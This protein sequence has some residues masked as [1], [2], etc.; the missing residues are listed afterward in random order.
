VSAAE[1]ELLR[2]ALEV[3]VRRI[4]G[5]HGITVRALWEKYDEANRHRPNWW[6]AANKTTPFVDEYSTRD[7]A[8][9]RVADWTSWAA[10]RVAMKVPPK[11]EHTYSLATVN[12]ELGNVKAMFNWGVTNGHLQYNPLAGA[13]RMKVQDRDTAPEE[14]EIGRALSACQDERQRVMVLAA[15]DVGLRNTEIRNLRHDWIDFE[16]KSL[17]LPGWACKNRR[18][19]TVPCTQRFLDA[20]RAVPRHI[21]LPQ[22][23]W[24]ERSNGPYC[25]FQLDTWWKGIRE[26]AGLMAAPGEREVR[27]HDLRAACA[28]NALD[29]GVGLVTI[30]RRI[31][32]HSTLATT[33]KY[34]RR[35]RGETGNLEQAIEAMEAGI[36]RDLEKRKGPKRANDDLDGNVL[37]EQKPRGSG[38]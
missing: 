30:S 13:K 31:L 32:R 20:V 22:V 12:V 21:R 35:R 25:S 29:R 15:A 10:K 18:G 4:S 36:K 11:L 6:A 28:T 27:L 9:L 8:A 26:R 34:L 17:T 1:D 3:A 14:H 16:A 5:G 23:L 37:H 7:A 24:S 38:T 2:A 33:E 19:G